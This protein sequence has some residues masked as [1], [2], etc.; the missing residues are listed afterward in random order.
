MQLI[1]KL[2]GIPC[3]LALGDESVFL[4]LCLTVTPYRCHLQKNKLDGIALRAAC[5]Q[6]ID[7]T[8][9][10]ALLGSGTSSGLDK[11]AFRFYYLLIKAHVRFLR[12]APTNEINERFWN[13]ICAHVSSGFEAHCRNYYKSILLRFRSVCDIR[14]VCDS[15]LISWHMLR[16]RSVRRSTMLSPFP[17]SLNS[18]DM[19][20]QSMDCYR[21]IHDQ[22]SGLIFQC[23]TFDGARMKGNTCGLIKIFPPR[24]LR[25][26]QLIVVAQ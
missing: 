26:Y 10:L 25:Q 7:N 11:S 16:C 1:W 3:R 12:F 24:H 4:W 2:S 14:H 17:L 13:A 21:T 22:H 8:I 20:L 6:T 5:K 18:S 9:V 19:I 15:L 23:D